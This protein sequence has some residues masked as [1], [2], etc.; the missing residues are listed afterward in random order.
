MASDGLVQPETF[1]QVSRYL[2]EIGRWEAI[3]RLKASEPRLWA[4]VTALAAQESTRF[5]QAT[6][7]NDLPGMAHDS[8][9]SAALVVAEILRRE[10]Y[11][12]W[13]DTAVG[14][15]LG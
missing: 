12:L 10:H 13:A 11:R 2:R 4:A 5:E 9:E 6:V 1:E 14:T 8:V 7:E 3:R 15:R